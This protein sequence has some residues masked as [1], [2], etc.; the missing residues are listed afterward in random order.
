MSAGAAIHQDVTHPSIDRYPK[1]FRA[2][3]GL[4][5]DQARD[6]LSFGCSS[7]EEVTSRQ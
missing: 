6:I 5:R 2:A 1:L 3:E 7:G 4:L